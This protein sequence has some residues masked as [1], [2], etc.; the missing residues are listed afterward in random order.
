[1][2][3]GMQNDPIKGQGQGYEPLKVE[4]SFHFQKLSPPPFTMGTGN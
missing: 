3:D 2:H 4:K 1:M